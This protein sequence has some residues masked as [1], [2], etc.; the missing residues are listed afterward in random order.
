VPTLL[1]LGAAKLFIVLFLARNARRANSGHW[2]DR[3]VDYRYLAERLRALYYLPLAGSFRPPAPAPLQFSARLMH[4]SAADWLFNAVARSAFPTDLVE[5]T[6]LASHDGQAEIR[7][8]LLR[9]D[10]LQALD[11]L[12][13]H[14]I[15]GQ[16]AYH[17]RNARTM[18]RLSRYAEQG[19]L[20]LSRAV[21][22][23]VAGDVLILLLDL[24]GQLPPPLAHLL[25]RTAPWLIAAAALL[26]AAVAAL[27]GL[28][29]QS[30]CQRLA[31]RSSRLHTLLAGRPGPRPVPG[32]GDQALA[33]SRKI[34]AAGTDADPDAGPDLGA[35][36]LDALLAHERVARDC[37]QEVAEWSVLY[38]KEL[39][40]T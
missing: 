11:R 36:T 16:I 31:D 3:A 12:R 7:V 38:A 18:H 35:W 27:N 17:D 24:L 28:S 34:A 8:R 2:A 26:P 25:H 37:V 13:N 29:F 5:D 22:L 32:R 15:R 21:V 23:I 33:L 6:S 39:R 9:P 10:A 20:L 19:G 30:E 1:G 40:D 4:Q 14:W